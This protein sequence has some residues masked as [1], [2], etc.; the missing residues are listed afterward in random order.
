MI[1]EAY[2]GRATGNLE[3]VNVLDGAATATVNIPVAGFAPV[4]EIVSGFGVHVTPGG[5]P[6][7]AQVIC[8][9]PVKPPLGV[10]VIVDVA[11]PPAVTVSAVPVTAN[12]PVVPAVTLM[13]F[14]AVAPDA[15]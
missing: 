15:A 7:P 10:T 4:T 5:N 3:A 11:L 9:S 14:A 6:M 2:S 12:V 1:A 13:I 8:T